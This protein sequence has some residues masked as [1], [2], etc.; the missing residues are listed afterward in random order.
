MADVESDEARGKQGGTAPTLR[1]AAQLSPRRWAAIVFGLG[2]GTLLEW[3]DFSVYSGLSS[4]IQKQFIP[5]GDRQAQ[6][7]SFWGIVSAKRVVL[8]CG[9]K[10]CGGGRA[11]SSSASP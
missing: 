10:R 1:D 4:T 8:C 5:S 2:L 7:L 6:A 3:F 9:E 11:C